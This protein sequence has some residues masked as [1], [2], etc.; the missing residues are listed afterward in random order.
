MDYSEPEFGSVSVSCERLK[1]QVLVGQ[2]E[3]LLA[4]HL[5]AWRC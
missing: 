1:R 4:E 3:A 2:G 5:N